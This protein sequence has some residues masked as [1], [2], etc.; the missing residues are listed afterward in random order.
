MR[1]INT[2]QQVKKAFDEL[3]KDLRKARIAATN[4]AGAT[5][6]THTIRDIRKSFNITARD[7]KGVNNDKNIKTSKA[8]QNKSSFTIYFKSE[9]IAL[10]YYKPKQTKSGIAVSIKKS[11]RNVLQGAFKIKSKFSPGE[12]VVKRLTQASYPVKT[13]YGPSAMQL[14]AAGQSQKILIEKFI[15]RFPIEFDRAYKHF[16]SGVNA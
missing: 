11:S 12:R 16:T 5:A 13:L 8:N 7:L 1:L 2:T 9:P 3:S 10:I 4:R 15:E 6:L 14:F